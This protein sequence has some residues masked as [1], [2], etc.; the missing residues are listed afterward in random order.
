MK[1]RRDIVAEYLFWL[2]LFDH[3]VEHH[4]DCFLKGF[5]LHFLLHYGDGLAEFLCL[6]E[7]YF[8]CEL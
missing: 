8:F 6:E 5:A 2:F 7:M 4:L 1:E 3:E